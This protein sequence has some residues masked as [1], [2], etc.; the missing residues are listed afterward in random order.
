MSDGATSIDQ[1]PVNT[2]AASTSSS[3]PAQPIS[4]PNLALLEMLN[5]LAVF[6]KPLVLI[7]S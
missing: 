2:Q 7:L 4:P 1:L 3:V 5:K 6:L